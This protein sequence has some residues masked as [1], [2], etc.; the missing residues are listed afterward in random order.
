MRILIGLILIFNCSLLFGQKTIYKFEKAE[1][2]DS[3]ESA[4]FPYQ[5]VDSL[6]APESLELIIANP[7]NKPINFVSSGDQLTLMRFE[8]HPYSESLMQKMYPDSN[9]QNYT[10]YVNEMKLHYDSVA[11]TEHE[12]WNSKNMSVWIQNNSNDTVVFPIQDGSL[13]GILE[14]QNEKKIWKPVQF[15][16]LSWCGNS[17]YEEY[18]YPNNSIQ[19]SLDNIRGQVETKLRIKIHGIDTIYTSSE[20]YGK[21]NE[22]SFNLPSMPESE[23][24]VNFHKLFLLDSVR[25]LVDDELI[26]IIEFES[27]Q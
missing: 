23:V 19:I 11:L 1:P 15:W 12:Y 21:V 14:A 13:I 18:L 10:A 3:M 7:A 2:T 5:I 6:F 8:N 16:W 9:Y 4:W 20:F 17:F 22:S 26:E 25:T 24:E 27:E